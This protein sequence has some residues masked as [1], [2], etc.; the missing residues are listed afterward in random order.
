MV[1]GMLGKIPD[2]QQPQ[3]RTRLELTERT[4]SSIEEEKNRLQEALAKK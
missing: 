2:V 1:C 3:V 4:H